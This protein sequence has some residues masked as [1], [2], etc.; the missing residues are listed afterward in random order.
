MELVKIA[1]FEEGGGHHEHNGVGA[2][3]HV[4]PKLLRC[5]YG[6]KHLFEIYSRILLAMMGSSHIGVERGPRVG[7]GVAGVGRGGRVERGR[8]HVRVMGSGEEQ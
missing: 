4:I 7:R 2:I 8:A 1:D 3:T 5:S 6:G